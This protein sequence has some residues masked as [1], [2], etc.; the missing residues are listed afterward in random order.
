MGRMRAFYLAYSISPVGKL[1][2]LPVFNISWG[3]NIAI[4]EGVKSL[5]ERL[6]YA[7]VRS[8]REHLS[9]VVIFF[10]FPARLEIFI[11]KNSKF[12]II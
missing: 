9:V 4:F 3:H 8:P 10:T 2:D 11:G 6:W 5:D 12:S 1:K 7:N